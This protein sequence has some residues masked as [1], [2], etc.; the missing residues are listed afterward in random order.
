MGGAIRSAALP[1]AAALAAVGAAA[2]SAGRAAAEDAQSQA[3]LATALT[4]NAGAT[5]TSIAATED[6]ISK[7]SMAT[8]VA[9][10]ELR[11][12]LAALVRATGDTERS[13]AALATALDVSAA[14]GKSV[15]S[16][17]QALAKGYAGN[18]S[19]LG[20]LV[21]GMDA[22]VVASGDMDQVMAELAKTTG[23][24][25]A[26][27]A[28]TAAGKMK[29]MEVAMGEAQE[30][31]GAALLPA[32]SALATV[33]AQ[34]A[35]F[36]GEHPQV[37][38]A[39]AVAV[40]GLAAA[41]LVANAAMSAYAAVTGVAT[42]IQTSY[43]TGGLLARAAALAQA[44]ASG[45]ATA[46]Q[47]AW[48]A[49]MAANPIGLVIIAVVALV[50]AMVLLYKKSDTVRD[51]VDATWAVAKAG[52]VAVADAVVGVV[53]KIGD[54]IGAIGRISVPGLIAAAFDTI[55]GAVE[56]AWNWVGNLITKIGNISVPG[57]IQSAFQ[58]IR[59]A[60]DAGWTKVGDLIAAIGR[61]SV[62]A[63]IKTAFDN[64]ASAIHS[65]ISAVESLIGWLSR[66]KVPDINLPGPLSVGGNTAP[67]V[68]AG[69]AV[70]PRVPGGRATPRAGG[71]GGINITVNGALDPEA[72]ARQIRRILAG[73]DRRMGLAT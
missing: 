47:W 21:P 59:D 14:T 50:A 27:A 35:V 1:A 29:I 32:M 31:A 52:A 30:S 17:S 72:T 39:I 3:L 49:A 23:G 69:L 46:A 7:Q 20:R 44:A 28:D 67:T 15:E 68:A 16:V 55:R 34:V 65:V 33:L 70:A 54:L 10:D 62:P 13:Q 36:A 22:A 63:V 73:H 8:G 56:A 4:K 9:D 43:T 12:A 26:A 11:P 45:V 19:A 5:K 38:M 18:T 37:F 58:A 51:I 6:W 42:A 2:V 64:L 48:N 60:V 40:A 41:I 53:R 25:A 61:I 57:A 24:S 71:S 66:I